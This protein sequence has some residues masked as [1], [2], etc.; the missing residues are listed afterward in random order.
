MRM[1]DI[2]TTKRDGGVLTNQ[3]IDFFI[4]FDNH[5]PLEVDMQALFLDEYGSVID[6]LFDGGTT[7]LYDEKSTIQCNITGDKLDNVMRAEKMALGLSVRTPDGEGQVIIKE[8]Q[9]IAIRMRILTKTSE[10]NID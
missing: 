4:D 7:I 8:S 1:V 3:E 5:I 6:Q 2:I 10:I 9:T